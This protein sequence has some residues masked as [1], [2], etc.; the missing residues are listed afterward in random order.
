MKKQKPEEKKESSSAK[1]KES[2][3]G[4][5]AMAALANRPKGSKKKGC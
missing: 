1:K 4:F 5:S 2:A 3:K